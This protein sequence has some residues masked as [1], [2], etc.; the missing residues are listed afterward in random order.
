MV[1][2]TE[3]RTFTL[4]EKQRALF[5]SDKRFLVYVGGRGGGKSTAACMRLLGMIQRGE[6]KPGARILIIGPD[7]TQLMDGT[8][9]TFDYWFDNAGMITHRVN[10]NKPSRILNGSVEVMCRSALNLDQT[11]SKECNPVWLDEFAQ[12]DES[13]FTLTNA[14]TRTTG[15]RDPDTLY[16]TIITTTPRG[17]NHLWRRFVNPETR[18]SDDKLDYFHITSI[19]A[20]EQGIA[21]PGYVEEMGYTEG[22]DIWNQ[23]ILAQYVSWSGLVFASFDA[24]K[25]TPLAIPELKN[26]QGGVDIGQSS[27]T[28]LLLGGEDQAGAVYIFKEYY[29]RRA[30]MHDWMRLAAEWTQQ[31]RVKAWHVDSAADIEIRAMRSAGLHVRPSIK[32]KDAANTAVGF[33]NSKLARGEFFIAEECYNLRS[34]METYQYKE[35]M[36]GDEVTFLDKVK[37][38]QADH[39]LDALRYLSIPLS[40]ASSQSGG[41]MWGKISFGARRA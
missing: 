37:P 21:R 15:V 22:S 32:K 20:E 25:H 11:R 26:V 12:Q 38:N 33:I 24:R 41:D 4:G 9:K 23:E 1:A 16:Q 5:W 17:K 13:I 39:A 40:A 34:E 19:E 3:S 29:Q 6:I 8:M 7:Y 14:A 36:S 35:L 28:C 18:I 31:Y 2:A 30:M 27:P 10:G